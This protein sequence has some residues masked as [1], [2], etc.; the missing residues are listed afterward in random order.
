MSRHRRADLHEHFAGW[1]RAAVGDRVAEHDEIV[2]HHLDQ[3]RRH[4]E[5]IGTDR[6]VSAPPGRTIRGLLDSASSPDEL[7]AVDK[8]ARGGV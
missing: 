2:T 4:R 8:G 7:E 5:G 3:A 1:L 6:H